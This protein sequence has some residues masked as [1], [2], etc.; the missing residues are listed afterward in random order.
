MDRIN[1]NLSPVDSSIKVLNKIGSSL[2]KVNDIDGVFKQTNR[3][4]SS[5]TLTRLLE[6]ITRITHTLLL[7]DNSDFL[8]S[9]G[10][11]LNVQTQV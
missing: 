1:S 7:T 11:K 9:D 8:M 4:Y 2:L 6:R 5:L 10:S 3:I